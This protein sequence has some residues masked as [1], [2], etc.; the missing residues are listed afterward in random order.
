M[1][2]YRTTYSRQS[3]RVI[4]SAPLSTKLRFTSWSSD[5]GWIV[6]TQQKTARVRGGGERESFSSDYLCSDWSFETFFLHSVRYA[7]SYRLHFVYL[8]V[9]LFVCFCLF[10]SLFLIVSKISIGCFCFLLQY[11]SYEFIR[12][13]ALSAGCLLIHVWLSDVYTVYIWRY[14]HAMFLCGGSY[15]LCI[16]IHV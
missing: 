4:Q 15:V 1:P 10:F 9:C 3:Y 11:W 16:N 7:Q 12:C 8:F 13:T 6:T 14:E 2:F 5:T